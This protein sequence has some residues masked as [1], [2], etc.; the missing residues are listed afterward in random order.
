MKVV[1]LRFTSVYKR[2]TYNFI[3]ISHAFC[4]LSYVFAA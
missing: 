3:Y 1:I 4:L 2:I